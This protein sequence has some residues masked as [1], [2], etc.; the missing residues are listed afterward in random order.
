[1]DM[2]RSKEFHALV[3]RA[4]TDED[5]RNRLLDPE[6]QDA[7]LKEVGVEPTPAVKEA[8][9]ASH[10]ALKSLHESFGQPV[11]AA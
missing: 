4:L 5:F 6:T 3:G 7:T 8:I 10:D 9:A 11:E 1:M 2:P